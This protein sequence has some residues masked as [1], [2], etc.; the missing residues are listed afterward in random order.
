MEK[1]QLTIFSFFF[2]KR[3]HTTGHYIHNFRHKRMAR[4]GLR[5]ARCVRTKM[6]N[7]SSKTNARKACGV[8]KR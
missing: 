4:S 2:S 5:K 7:G 8:K 6:K 1:T 3:Y